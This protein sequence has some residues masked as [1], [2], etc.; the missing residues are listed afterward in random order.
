MSSV[1]KL[2]NSTRL[3]G[4]TGILMALSVCLFFCSRSEAATWY[5]NASAPGG[6]NGTSPAKA[7]QTIQAAANVAAPGDTVK[8]KSGI[9]RETVTPKNSGTS[10]API[11]YEPSGTSDIVTVSGADD[12]TK[13]LTWSPTPGKNYFQSPFGTN[14]TYTTTNNQAEQLYV[15]GQAMV[16]ARYPHLP[17]VGITSLQQQLACALVWDNPGI[18]STA[19]NSGSP[20][21]PG[22]YPSY[23][24]ASAHIAYPGWK[25]LTDTCSGLSNITG[26]INGALI[27]VRPV[28]LPNLPSWGFSMTGYVNS[29]TSGSNTIGFDLNDQGYSG[30]EA[31][32]PGTPFYLQSNPNVASTLCLMGAPGEWYHDVTNNL[33][34]LY[35]P[36]G[37]SP[38]GNGDTIEIKRRDYA[39]DLDSKSYITIR[40]I[41]VF[42][43]TITTDEMAGAGGTASGANHDTSSWTTIGRGDAAHGSPTTPAPS[44]HIILDGIK[45]KYINHFTDCMGWPGCQWVQSSGIVVSGTYQTIENSVVDGADGN[46]VLCLG[47]NNT[48]KNNVLVDTNIMGTCAAAINGGNAEHDQDFRITENTVTGTGFDGIHVDHLYSTNASTPAEVDHNRVSDFGVLCHDVGAIKVEPTSRESFNGTRW[49]HNLLSDGDWLSFAIYWD[50]VSGTPGLIADHNITWNVDS[51]ANINANQGCSLYN[52]TFLAYNKGAVANGT[53]AGDQIVNNI[54]LGESSLPSCLSGGTNSNNIYGATGA[55]FVK[56]DTG[57][58]KLQSTASTAIGTG[59]NLGAPYTP[60]GGTHGLAWD[61]GAYQHPN[62]PWWNKGVGSTVAYLQPAPTDLTAVN[63]GTGINL[64]WTNNAASAANVYVERAVANGSRHG[65]EVVAQLPATSTTWTDNGSYP[66]NQGAGY[67]SSTL[68]YRVRTEKS[69]VSNTVP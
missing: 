43:A 29:H 36:K 44:S 25:R 11:I 63:T 69:M 40:N 67:L 8:I 24:P 14:T 4:I 64:K 22:G 53:V 3:A 19:D 30:L 33:I 21:T 18:L 34:Y 41:H 68:F 60:D 31:N 51:G 16:E 7:F 23:A 35:D 57:D 9:Y 12:I 65:F 54:F 58:V 5:V 39:F 2:L 28:E 52:N 13:N 47:Q 42:A 59:L 38:S 6:G 1:Q 55:L 61:I 27:C 62:T 17:Y 10:L 45:A 20:A 66:A 32:Y 46:G 48:V 56:P 50:T 15:N 49:D 26:N 37:G